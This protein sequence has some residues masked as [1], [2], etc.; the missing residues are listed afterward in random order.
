MTL[1]AVRLLLRDAA[2]LSAG[3]RRR[4]A[5]RIGRFS[6]P[7]WDHC[8]YQPVTDDSKLVERLRTRDER[9]FQQLVRRHHTS[10][11][12]VARSFVGNRATAEE[13]VQDTW[14]AVLE[15]ID[16]FEQRSSLKA[17]IFGVLV[18]KARTRALRDGRMLSFSDMARDDGSLEPVVD[19]AR[20]TGSGSWADPPGPWDDL[21]P[22]RVVAGQQLWA[23]VMAA[24]EDLP[25]SQRAVL[26]MRDVAGHGSEET[27][28]ILSISEAN[29]RVLLHRA[30]ARMRQVIETLIAPPESAR[31]SNRLP[32]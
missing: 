16:R 3:R 24:I 13:V 19:P 20:F 31:R 1:P 8:R 30:R 6:E 21:N 7:V 18:N 12:G 28:S 22:E 17:W 5:N 14:L 26:I 25:P 11:V 32:Q 29:Q 15:G 9:A 2:V 23:H 4:K 27:C 10:M